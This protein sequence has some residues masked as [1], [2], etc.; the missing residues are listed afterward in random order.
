MYFNNNSNSN[1]N[2]QEKQYLTKAGTNLNYQT[3]PTTSS[4]IDELEKNSNNISDNNND[5]LSNNNDNI[6]KFKYTSRFLLLIGCSILA[7]LIPC[8]ELV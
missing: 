4:S 5:N 8:F 1:N 3:I 6:D 7:N 2:Y